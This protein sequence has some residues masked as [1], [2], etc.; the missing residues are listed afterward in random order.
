VTAAGG[1]GAG[2]G[3][4]AG[5][6]A[7]HAANGPHSAIAREMRLVLVIRVDGVGVR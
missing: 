4:A 6:V 5:G 7:V 2:S 1:A 3:G